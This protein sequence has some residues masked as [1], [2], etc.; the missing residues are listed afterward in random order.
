METQELIKLLIRDVLV[1]QNGYSR[2]EVIAKKLDDDC[3][4]SE[5]WDAFE[6]TFKKAGL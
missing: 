6:K 4:G 5:L 2:Q 1:V 3:Y